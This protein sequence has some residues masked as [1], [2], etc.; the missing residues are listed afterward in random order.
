MYKYKKK[1]TTANIKYKDCI[2]QWQSSL[3]IKENSDQQ[4]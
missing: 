1:T 2:I 3:P 4:V